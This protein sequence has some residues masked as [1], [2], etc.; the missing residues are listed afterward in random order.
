MPRTPRSLVIVPGAPHHIIVRGNNRRRLFSYSTCY[1]RFLRELESAAW[2]YAVAIHALVLM[3]NHAHLVATPRSCDELSACMHR[4]GQQYAVF[5]NRRRRASGK[6]FEERFW[7]RP[8]V[9]AL[10]FARVVPY[11]E[12]NPERAGLVR[13]LSEHRWSTYWLHAG[14]PERSVVPPTLWTPSPWWT[15]LGVSAA[16]RGERHRDLV[17]TCRRAGPTWLEADHASEI[18][19][20]EAA[21]APYGRRLLRP[22]GSGAAE[23]TV[24]FRR[25]FR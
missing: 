17:A 19:R 6:L 18:E 15:S 10:Y 7:A 8:I 5:R 3:T 13:D 4:L 2:Q 1:E 14:R 16:E 24:R 22:D 20:H 9:D 11:V 21:S 25:T 12:L 23:E